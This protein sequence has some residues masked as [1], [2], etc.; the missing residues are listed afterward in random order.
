MREARNRGFT[1]IEILVVVAI[2]G[3]LAAVAM[4]MY[5]DYSKRAKL[6]EVV[7]AASACR[8]TVTDVYVQSGTTAVSAATFGCNV[9][10]VASRYVKTISTDDKGAITVVALGFDDLD[11][12]NRAIVLTP[13]HDNTTVKDPAVAGHLGQPVFKWVCG[14]RPAQGIPARLLPHS[15]RGA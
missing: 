4:P 5:Q 8:T 9:S 10:A 14:P 15:C 3:I 1:L 13:Y 6:T 2:I 12:D 7:L 11:I